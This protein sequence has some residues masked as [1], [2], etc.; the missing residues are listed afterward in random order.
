[1]FDLIEWFCWL[2][3]EPHSLCYHDS[4]R[5]CNFLGKKKRV[6]THRMFMSPL[7]KCFSDQIS[8][9]QKKV[10]LLLE[11]NSSGKFST[12]LWKFHLLGLIPV[13]LFLSQWPFLTHPKATRHYL[14][15]VPVLEANQCW[16]H[17]HN[18]QQ[19]SVLL[20]H[21]QLD[22]P[23]QYAQSKDGDSPK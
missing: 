20:P 19:Q 17:L 12:S 23:F 15:A 14:F 16:Q 10:I 9:L 4:D 3:P 2:H 11:T 8:A 13:L 21:S 18:R 6:L 1:M 22:Q 7:K 5:A